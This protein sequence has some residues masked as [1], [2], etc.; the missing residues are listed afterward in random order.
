VKRLLESGMTAR[1]AADALG[2]CKS[3][4]AYHARRFGIQPDLRFATRYDWEEIRVAYESGL[5]MRECMRDF[6]FSSDAWAK[7][8]SRG[9]VVPRPRAIPLE[10]MLVAG[11]KRGR[12][13]L[14][15]RLLAE[16]LKENRCERC[17][18]T[19]WRGKPLNM[20]LHHKNG[21]GTDNRLENLEL[22][23]P[24]CHSQTDTYGG[25]NGHRRKN[26]ALSR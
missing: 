19:E 23:C 11:R 1:E 16:G 24:N 17:G 5:S 20:A 26:S 13:N 4:V 14:K 7:A 3:T 15:R 2:I 22:L 8:V 9:A 21:D 18:L 12:W 6:G 25:R 10:E